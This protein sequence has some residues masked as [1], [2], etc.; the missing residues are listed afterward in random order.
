MFRFWLKKSR[1]GIWRNTSIWRM[2]NR[3]CSC[4]VLYIVST[5]VICWFWMVLTSL[6]SSIRIMRVFVMM[7]IKILFLSTDDSMLPIMLTSWSKTFKFLLRV[8]SIDG[9]WFKVFRWLSCSRQILWWILDMYFSLFFIS[10][11]AICLFDLL[12]TFPFIFRQHD[13]LIAHRSKII[14]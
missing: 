8:M 12:C 10:C 14:Y 13:V 5:W 7:I 2:L 6:C 11:G 3:W 9:S 1:R 4:R